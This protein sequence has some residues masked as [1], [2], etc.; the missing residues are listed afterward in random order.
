[1]SDVPV[2]TED[3][4]SDDEDNNESDRLKLDSDNETPARLAANPPAQDEDTEAPIPATLTRDT[5]QPS[6]RAG[7]N[8]NATAG[9]VSTP[10]SAA[11]QAAVLQNIVE[12]EEWILNENSR[13]QTAARVRG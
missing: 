2:A 9:R 5:L 10:G 7:R 11:V 1:M 8:A 6:A 3:E 4:A 12:H 13:M